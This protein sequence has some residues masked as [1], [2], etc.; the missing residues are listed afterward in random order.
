MKLPK[1]LIKKYG[2]SKK[3]WSVFKGTRSKVS[4]KTTIRSVK[5]MARHRRIKH[6]SRHSRGL[7]SKLGSLMP[8]LG[9]A[10]YGVARPYLNQAAAPLMAKMP[11]GEY[12]NEILMGGGATLIKMLV[13]NPTVRGL[14]T[15]VQIIEAA[16]AAETAT[17]GLTGGAQSGGNSGLQMF[18]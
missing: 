18:Y 15:P 13:K 4:R 11:F 14:M 5:Q 2:I 1:N 12:N 17:R 6:Y 7:G 10:I 9:G 8:I 3:A 16:S